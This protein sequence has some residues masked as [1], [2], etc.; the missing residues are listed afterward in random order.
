MTAAV[1]HTLHLVPSAPGAEDT[2]PPANKKPTPTSPKALCNSGNRNTS[3]SAP[4]ST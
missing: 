3:S 2:W 1:R 4:C